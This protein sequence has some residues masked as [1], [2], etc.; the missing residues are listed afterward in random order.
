MNNNTNNTNSDSINI[1]PESS[2]YATYERLSYKPSYAL[3]EFVDNSTASYFT[4]RDKLREFYKNNLN[5]DYNLN[6]YILYINSSVQPQITII[7]NAYGMDRDEL[8]RAVLLGK[9]PKIKNG[10]NE[11]GMGL[12][13]AATWFSRKWSVTTTKL[14]SDQEY[15]VTMD[16]DK[17]VAENTRT[18]EVTKN[19]VAPKLHRTTLRLEKLNKPIT[20][21]T[22][23]T[24]ISKLISG[25]YR[26]DIKSGEVK[27]YFAEMRTDGKWRDIEGKEYERVDQVPPIKFEEVVPRVILPG[28]VKGITEPTLAVG[29]D[30]DSFEFNNKTYRVK[31]MVGIRDKGSRTDAGFTLFR[32]NRAIVGGSTDNYRPKSIFG[33]SGSFAYQRMYGEIDL[34][35]FPVNQAKDGFSWDDG[36]EEAF[37]NFL[38]KKIQTFKSWAEKLRKFDDSGA[39]QIKIKEVVEANKDISRM[40]KGSLTIKPTYNQNTASATKK[41]E[42]G[43]VDIK[44]VTDKISLNDLGNIAEF[45]EDGIEFSFDLKV[46]DAKNPTEWVKIAVIDEEKG[47]YAIELFVEHLFLKPLAQEPQFILF[48]K[49]FTTAYVCAILYLRAGS[50][51]NTVDP[52]KIT[53]K[54]NEFLRG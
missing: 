40:M 13:T 49:K 28:Q 17:I 33:D 45:S 32:R 19:T 51:D 34:D 46:S 3:A 11:F 54:L 15:S 1:Q 4:N 53:K 41:N 42:P 48:M 44:E 2:I 20:T 18:V 22:Q 5:K 43:Q 16:I 29:E 14:G 52:L 25:M 9:P 26:R 6:V 30:E 35:D 36:L 39:R 21:K 50:P 12:K 8:E 10:R 47:K 23:K 24:A 38:S 7:D 31:Y 27:I 37:I